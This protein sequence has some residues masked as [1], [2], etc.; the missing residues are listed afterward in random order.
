MIS[1]GASAQATEKGVINDYNTK[2][3]TAIA[4]FKSTNANVRL[5]P[6]RV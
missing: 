5:Y 2:L 3:T 4:N 1:S 6:F